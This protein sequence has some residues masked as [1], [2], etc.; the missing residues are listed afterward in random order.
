MEQIL[1]NKQ[2]LLDIR[3]K[4]LV[5]SAT[6]NLRELG[7]MN[8]VGRHLSATITMMNELLRGEENGGSDRHSSTLRNN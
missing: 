3:Q 2:D 6:I 4:L 5:A 7:G 8:E 1:I